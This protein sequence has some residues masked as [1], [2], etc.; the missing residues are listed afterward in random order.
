LEQYYIWLAQQALLWLF[1]YKYIALLI[2]ANMFISII[3][4]RHKV[5]SFRVKYSIVVVPFLFPILLLLIGAIFKHNDSATQ[6]I[7]LWPQYMIGFL[8]LVQVGISVYSIMM[9]KMFRWLATSLAL[10]QLLLSYC[11]AFIAYMSVTGDWL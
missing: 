3:N 8:L 6:D 10:C 11:A 7:L 1:H 5:D 9:M 2:V 4:S